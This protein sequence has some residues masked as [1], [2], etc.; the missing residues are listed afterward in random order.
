VLPACATVSDIFAGAIDT[1]RIGGELDCVKFAS[2][3]YCALIV[4]FPLGNE[5]AV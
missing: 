1:K 4:M 3:L 5:P 2:P